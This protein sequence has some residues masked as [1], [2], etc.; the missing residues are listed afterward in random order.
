M[1]YTHLTTKALQKIIA[2][3][4]ELLVQLANET[5]VLIEHYKLEE[6]YIFQLQANVVK[7]RLS[8][9]CTDVEKVR[10][11]LIEKNDP[12]TDISIQLANQTILLASQKIE[13][14]SQL[15]SHS[16]ECQSMSNTASQLENQS[17]VEQLKKILQKG[18]EKK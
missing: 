16:R 18:N 13:L 10:D 12:A 5:T 17:A 7:K 9:L 3:K 2:E 8:S 4:T 1:T 6:L 11:A 15:L 14:L